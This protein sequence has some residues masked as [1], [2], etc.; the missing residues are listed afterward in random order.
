V[1][2]PRSHEPCRAGRGGRC[3]RDGEGRRG[4]VGRDP[5]ARGVAAAWPQERPGLPSTSVA[6]LAQAVGAMV[7]SI[8]MAGAGAVTTASRPSD[9]AGSRRRRLTLPEG[10]KPGERP[11]R[12]VRMSTET[13]SHSWPW[14]CYWLC[15]LAGWTYPTGCPRCRARSTQFSMCSDF[16]TG[17]W[18]EAQPSRTPFITPARNGASPSDTE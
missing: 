5:S 10:R 11:P 16:V 15:L 6:A 2:A 14:P 12:R 3:Q 13:G 4:G 1:A 7:A 9:L 18:R 17:F 8:V